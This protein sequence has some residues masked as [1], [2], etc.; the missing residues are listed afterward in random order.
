VSC[1]LQ[2]LLWSLHLP[3]RGLWTGSACKAVSSGLSGTRAQPGWT[4][5]ASSH[6][7]LSTLDRITLVMPPAAAADTAAAQQLSALPPLYGQCRLAAAS[8][9]G[10]SL[11]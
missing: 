5:A 4:N 9:P 6:S 3:L 11:Q 1:L 10:S 8:S 2:A 7:G